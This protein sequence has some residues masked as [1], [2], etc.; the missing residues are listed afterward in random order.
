MTPVKPKI[1]TNKYTITQHQ[2]PYKNEEQK[3]VFMK[4][5]YS[6][7]PNNSARWKAISGV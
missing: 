6:L 1:K 2:P 5:Q 3:Q 7:F 4:G